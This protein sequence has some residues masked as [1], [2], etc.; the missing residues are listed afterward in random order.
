MNGVCS[1]N[2]LFIPITTLNLS[3]P[4]YIKTVKSSIQIFITRTQNPD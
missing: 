4:H 3:A 1:Q 2:I